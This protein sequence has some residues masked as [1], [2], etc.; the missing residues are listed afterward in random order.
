MPGN[1]LDVDARARARSTTRA[2][3]DRRAAGHG[4]GDLAVLVRGLD[5]VRRDRGVHRVEVVGRS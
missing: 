4:V 1:E 2:L 5:D 3:R